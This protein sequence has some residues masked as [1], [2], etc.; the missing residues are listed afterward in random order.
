[1]AVRL[2]PRHCLAG[3][4]LAVVIVLLIR[5]T[6]LLALEALTDRELNHVAAQSGISLVLDGANPRLDVSADS[7]GTSAA[8][9]QLS[10]ASSDH[11]L[12]FYD[13]D[14]PFLQFDNEVTA[15]SICGD[16][17]GGTY[18][19]FEAATIDSL[20]LT[21]DTYTW[22]STGES[23]IVLKAY[24]W[25]G[26]MYIKADALYA[27][28]S[29]HSDNKLFGLS[30]GEIDLVDFDSDGGP[31]ASLSVQSHAA[32]NQWGVSG[33]GVDLD[34][35]MQLHVH[36]IALYPSAG[37]TQCAKDI[38][39]AREF[40]GTAWWDAEAA[41]TNP[42]NEWVPTGPFGS[43]GVP[44]D[45]PL[46]I[47]ACTVNGDQFLVLYMAG[48]HT[49]TYTYPGSQLIDYGIASLYPAIGTKTVSNHIGAGRVARFGYEDGLVDGE[50][51]V[52]GLSAAGNI[53]Y[54]KI[55]IPVG[56]ITSWNNLIRNYDPLIPDHGFNFT[57][58]PSDLPGTEQ[59][60]TDVNWDT[61]GINWNNSN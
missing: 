7:D 58:D 44:D 48:H 26:E 30:I 31:L 19:D 53:I 39:L 32:T 54:T 52:G 1:M 12:E 49:A 40:N 41:D 29:G 51:H 46:S 10:S 43:N 11:Y 2:S 35:F 17:A 5:P 61:S 42:I 33:S 36:E 38:I 4:L 25:S 8:F 15:V 28:D 3:M 21:L 55:V 60:I 23:G 47:D 16:G 27:N 18:Q 34:L 50:D 45:R 57:Y 24:D 9:L 37:V 56:D 6:P 14:D 20:R 59:T 13:D 22:D